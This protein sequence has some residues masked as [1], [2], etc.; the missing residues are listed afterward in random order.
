MDTRAVNNDKISP[1]PTCSF[2]EF[3]LSSTFYL[4]QHL[5][6]LRELTGNS[7]LEWDL[8][9]KTG[10]ERDLYYNLYQHPWHGELGLFFYRKVKG[11]W[12]DWLPEFWLKHK[13]LGLI[14]DEEIQQTNEALLT[15][16]DAQHQMFLDEIERSEK[17]Q[18]IISPGL[19]AKSPVN[20]WIRSSI[21]Q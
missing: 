15:L 8:S 10:D 21:L 20:Q 14:P 3:S 19:A 17:N 5:S 11:L 7:K 18:P 13:L 6:L 4:P 1:F 9:A 2:E 12:I 16:W